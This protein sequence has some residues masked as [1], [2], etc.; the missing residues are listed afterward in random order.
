MPLENRHPFPAEPMR[1]VRVKGSDRDMGRQHGEQVGRILL[2]GMPR[3]Y[4]E[5][6]KR[7]IRNEPEPFLERQ[8][9]RVV[10]G[11]IERVLVPRLLAAIPEERKSA[12]AACRRR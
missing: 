3:F 9:F 11:L 5:F 10:R 12:S 1:V 6:W 2:D 7:M 4:Y 8:G